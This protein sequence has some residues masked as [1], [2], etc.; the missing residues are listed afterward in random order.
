MP[1]SKEKTG[2][3]RQNKNRTP[4]SFVPAVEQAAKILLFFSQ[5]NSGHANLTEICNAVGIYKSRGHAILKTLAAYGIIERNN[6][7]KRYSL[8]PAVL[9]LSRSLLRHLDLRTAALPHL[10]TLARE[11]GCTALVGIVSGEYFIV[12]AKRDGGTPLGITIEVGHRFPLTAG[13]HGKT[14]VAFLPEDEQKK[15]L[16]RKK[17]YFYGNPD[18]FDRSRFDEDIKSCLK[19]GYALD[20]GDLQPGIHAAAAPVF[21]VGDRVTGAVIAVGTFPQKTALSIGEKVHEAARA[22]SQ[23]MGAAMSELFKSFSPGV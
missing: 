8:G 10:E 22:I 19:T 6:A 2:F 9:A 4:S 16:K 12:I 13:A 3:T 15:I 20:M 11:S 7:T 5:N 14:I 18:K 17:L 1:T 21:T 23:A